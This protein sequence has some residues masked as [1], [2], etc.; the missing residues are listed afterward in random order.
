MYTT[1]KYILLLFAATNLFFSCK[2]KSLLPDRFRLSLAQDSGYIS[3]GDALNFLLDAALIDTTGGKPFDNYIQF[4][5]LLS[6]A[7][8]SDTNKYFNYWPAA[9][10]TDT[11]GKYYAFGN[12]GNYLVALSL[13]RGILLL[14]LTPQSD[15]V[16]C[17]LLGHGSHAC[18]WESFDDLLNRYGPY[19]GVSTCGTGT[20][21]C[22]SH[23]HLY[24]D[25]I[26]VSQNSIPVF[27]FVGAWAGGVSGHILTSDMEFTDSCLVMHYEL[28]KYSEG[29]DN[30]REIISTECFTVTYIYLDGR[31]ETDEAYKLEWML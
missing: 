31:F 11:L 1:F 13:D 9:E 8:D 5:Y 21:Y 19:F 27:E 17:D 6:D 22:S 15:I 30:K 23:I 4:A 29:E 3:S 14:E 18:C 2:P 28:E 10:P 20:A 12:K 26:D 7:S 25:R 24:K 16:Y